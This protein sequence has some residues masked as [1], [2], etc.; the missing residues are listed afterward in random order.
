MPPSEPLA[1]EESPPAAAPP[2][3]SSSSSSLRVSHFERG[4]LAAALEDAGADGCATGPSADEPVDAD[5]AVA[6]S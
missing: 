5:E 1:A 2:V 6:A 3:L 4:R